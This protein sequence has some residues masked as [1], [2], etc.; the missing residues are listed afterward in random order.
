MKVCVGATGV[1][2]LS[3]WH[4]VLRARAAEAG[5]PEAPWHVTRMFPKRAVEILDRGSLYWTINSV[6]AVRQ[7]I[8]GLTV[9][10]GDDGIKRCRIDLANELVTVEPIPRRP[11]QGWRYL[12]PKDAPRD[13]GA[14]GTVD[15]D[16]QA[17]HQTL[18]SLGLL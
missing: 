4:D 15:A 18:S 17:L 7:E 8:T 16:S 9:V 12:D 5:E 2:S 10:T 6:F 3:A 13:V 11:F 14:V 1:D